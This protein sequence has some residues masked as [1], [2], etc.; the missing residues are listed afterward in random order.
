MESYPDAGNVLHV[1]L[2]SCFDQ[3][4]EDSSVRALRPDK[5]DTTILSIDESVTGSWLAASRGLLADAIA[6]IKGEDL[7][8]RKVLLD[9]TPRM[10]AD[11]RY[12]P[13]EHT[14]IPPRTYRDSEKSL[15]TKYLLKTVAAAGN[16]K[17]EEGYVHFLTESR[18]NATE[19]RKS[20]LL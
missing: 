18:S 10:R 8:H 6:R 2:H 12:A 20:V 7:K 17:E 9:V 16:F 19:M 1:I 14:N 4:C 11:N 15:E 3:C 13:K 5:T